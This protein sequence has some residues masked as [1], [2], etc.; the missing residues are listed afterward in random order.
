M[1]WFFARSGERLSCEIHPAEDGD[2]YELVWNQNG[3]TRKERFST[4]AAA[5]ARRREVEAKLKHDGWTR[6]GRE[7]PPAHPDAK[8]FL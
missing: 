5:V 4:A 1:I 6:V 7:T 3:D 2:G 8:R